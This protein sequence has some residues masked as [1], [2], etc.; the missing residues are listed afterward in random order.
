MVCRIAD[1]FGINS[2]GDVLTGFKWIGS[3]IDEI[4]PEK[5]VFGFE[6]AHGYLAGTYARDKDA[7]VAAMLLAEL[8]AECKSEGRT[9]HEQLDQLFLKY[10]CHLERT[11]GHTL[12]GADGLAK[13]Q[14]AMQRLRTRPPA[15]LGGMKVAAVRDYLCQQVTGLDANIVSTITSVPPSDLLIFDLESA[16]NRAAVRP[17]GTEPKLKF[18][19]FTYNMPASS[20]ELPETKRRLRERLDR[21]EADLLAAANSA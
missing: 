9:L 7:G 10:G 15:K 21:L 14:Q 16:G 20:K 13:M 17:S 5:F 1:H 19:L 3:K 11:I 6:E 2:V 4:G 8:A 12:P 18:Y